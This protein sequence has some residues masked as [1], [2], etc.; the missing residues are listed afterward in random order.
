MADEAR[1][2]EAYKAR[3]AKEKEALKRRLQ[4]EQRALRVSMG[5]L[6]KVSKAELQLAVCCIYMIVDCCHR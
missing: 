2:A 1:K 5:L 4:S 3:R 6:G